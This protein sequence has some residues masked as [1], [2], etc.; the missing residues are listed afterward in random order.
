MDVALI[1][2]EGRRDFLSAGLKKV[3]AAFGWAEKDPD[4]PGWSQ[5]LPLTRQVP[6]SISRHWPEFLPVWEQRAVSKAWHKAI[7]AARAS[8]AI[9]QADGPWSVTQL[10]NVSSSYLDGGG[11]DYVARKLELEPGVRKEGD[12]ALLQGKARILTLRG[13]SNGDQAQEVARA[14]GSYRIEIL[15]KEKAVLSV[16]TVRV[17]GQGQGSQEDLV[18]SAGQALSRRL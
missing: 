9:C 3:L 2:K 1:R 15:D 18:F 4:A 11:M 8:R 5:A 14:E 16:Q 6:G 17:S 12:E 13:N 10:L 7:V